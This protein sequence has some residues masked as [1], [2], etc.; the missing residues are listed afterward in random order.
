MQ[1]KFLLPNSLLHS[2]SLQKQPS[3]EKSVQPTVKKHM[4][5][6]RNGFDV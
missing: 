3:C 5:W 1:G 4:Q 6:S 2:Q